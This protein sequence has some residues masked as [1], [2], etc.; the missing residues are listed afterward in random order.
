MRG[1]PF[2][3]SPAG[4]GPTTR[5][6]HVTVPCSPLVAQVPFVSLLPRV[7]IHAAPRSLLLRLSAWT[8]NAPGNQ[9]WDRQQP[10][11]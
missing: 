2:Q 11:L 1:V 3:L 9:R 4:M 8:Q 7:I 5:F 10:R 6:W